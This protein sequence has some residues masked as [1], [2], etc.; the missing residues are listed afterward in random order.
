M[1]LDAGR[2]GGG[3]AELTA[4]DD[5]REVLE[6]FRRLPYGFGVTSARAAGVHPPKTGSAFG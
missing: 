4:F 6:V 5:L 1:F 3:S 2:S